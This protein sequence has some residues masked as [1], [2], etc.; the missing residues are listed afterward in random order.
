M[1]ASDWRRCEGG[2]WYH[3]GSED[4]AAH[5]QGRKKRPCPECETDKRAV[6]AFIAGRAEGKREILLALGYC[7]RCEGSGGLAF[8]RSGGMSVSCPDCDE[9]GRLPEEAANANN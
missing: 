7:P 6:E 1:G 2:G 5:E 3:D 4:R 9:T 8:D